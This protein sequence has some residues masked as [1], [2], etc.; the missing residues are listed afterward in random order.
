MGHRQ[1]V[2][3]EWCA[4]EEDEFP[5]GQFDTIGETRV[6]KLVSDVGRASFHRATDG[7]EVD[8]QVGA[9]KPKET[10]A[11]PQPPGFVMSP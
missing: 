9:I 2:K 7:I 10:Q 1:G 5:I 11:P 3:Q 4:R 8:I 6:H